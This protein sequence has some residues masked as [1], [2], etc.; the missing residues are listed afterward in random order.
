MPGRFL[1]RKSRTLALAG[2]LFA[3]ATA[4]PLTAV[5]QL[6]V[7]QNA[8]GTSRPL[9]LAPDSPFRDPD[10]IYLEAN[11]VINDE[12]ANVLTAIGEVEGRYQDRTLR[13][14]RVDYNL[15][16]GV[17]LA[18]G[19]VVLIDA[20]G[21]VQYAD[22]IELSD[23]LQAGTAANF[24][25]RLASGATTAA[26]FVARDE[27]GEFELY[28]VTYTACEL[29]KNSEGETE[30]P[31]WRLK[32]R[33]VR[34]DDETRTI[35]YRDAVIEL[36]GIPIFYSPY[37][38]H[39]DPSQDRASGLLIPTV[40]LS[41]SRGATY[42]Q[43]YY[44]AIDDYSEA[45]I[46]PR[47][48]SSV[49]PLLELQ[50]RR[51]FNTGEI[52]FA[53][54][55]TYATLFDQNG[56]PLD[57]PARFAIPSQAEKGPEWS[58]HF[59]L[60]GYFRP[61]RQWSWGYTTMVQTDDTY[62]DRYGVSSN[63]YSNGLFEYIPRRN[64]TQAFVAGQGENYRISAVAVG[65]QGLNSFFL[66]DETTGQVFA[67][68]DNDDA[69]PIIAPRIQ[70]EYY[71]NDPLLDGRARLFGDLTYLTREDAN[72]YGRATAG[73]D[74]SKTWIAPGGLEVKPFAWGR[75]DNYELETRAG[76]PIDFNRS[77]GQAGVDIR[78]P[79]IRPGDA[80]DLII[81]PRVKY[82]ESFGDAKLDRFVDPATGL[83]LIEDGT[84]PDLDAELLFETN[85]AD[86]LDFFEEGRRIDVGAEVAARWQMN[87]RDS[88]VS[89]FAGRS[90]ADGI[91]NSFDVGSGLTN[92]DSEYVAELEFDVAG[93]LDGNLLARYDPVSGDVVRVD[94][95]I[96]ARSKFVDLSARYYRLGDQPVRQIAI[97]A[98]Q[99][100][101][102]GSVVV[103]PMDNLSLGY[104]VVRDLEQAVTRS[105]RFS[106]GY[107]D[108]CTLVEL[109]LFTQDFGNDII[110]NEFEIGVRLTL[111]TLGSI[112]SQ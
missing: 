103:R 73:L 35:R 52:N 13:A 2:T 47:I 101:V 111:A 20:T 66:E 85:K 38:A 44:W 108:D 96:R 95:A 83:S 110:R 109:F 21:D 29:C 76:T 89:L 106:L 61:S 78:Y 5:A 3:A 86:G 65:F 63:F 30:R 34:Q 50:A 60:D 62:L 8:V 67:V 54:S 46:T 23:E 16:T 68:R 92:G 33:R 97:G 18:T 27:N 7:D 70:G 112:G 87:G 51:K 43:P 14:E 12:A 31:T 10:L 74:Y 81:E 84:S 102:S 28:N 26:R 58:S 37:L 104:Q 99:E 79:F 90:Y 32:A 39:P 88:E 57:D 15:N 56:D 82:T 71:V 53:G 59:F 42:V 25:A 17:V 45:T 36:F 41:Q 77:L 105:Q 100:E 11:E 48:Y 22:K 94:S 91:Q 93:F 72:D 1:I 9:Q 64:T 75:F 6:S 55:F 69:L 107:R 49:N 98:P 80:F 4:L 40:G 24:T 19:D